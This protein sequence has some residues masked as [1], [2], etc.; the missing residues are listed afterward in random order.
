MAD[1]VRQELEVDLA[2]RD[3]AVVQRAE[4]SR[5]EVLRLAATGEGLI[6][7]GGGIDGTPSR[8]FIATPLEVV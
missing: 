6:E 3:A 2:T 4:V 7:D 8:V 1:R 5:P